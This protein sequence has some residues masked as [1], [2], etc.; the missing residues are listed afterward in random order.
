MQ[1]HLTFLRPATAALIA[2]GASVTIA[3]CGGS[4]PSGS[5]APSTANDGLK[6]A[7]CVRAHGVPD[8][9]DPRS[10]E[11]NVDTHTLSESSRVVDTAMSN[12][13]KYSASSATANDPRLSAAQL[14]T[15]RT[16]ALAYAKCMRAHGLADFPDPTVAV[17][18]GGRGIETGYSIPEL[19]QHSS[20]FHSPAYDSDNRT[21]GKAWASIFLPLLHKKG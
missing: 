19:K 2:L 18:P 14:A 17:G 9:P 5:S 12:C 10:G 6:F 8:Y 11:V 7:A 16:G 15:V 3:A 1:R 20:D 13:Q 4:S 21:C